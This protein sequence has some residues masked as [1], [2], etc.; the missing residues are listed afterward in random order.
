ME[1]YDLAPLSPL[2]SNVVKAVIKH[3][4]YDVYHLEDKMVINADL[5]PKF[6]E[7][8]MDATLEKKSLE[9]QLL[10]I[11]EREKN[12][13]KELEKMP[14]PGQKL[15]PLIPRPLANAPLQRPIPQRMMPRPIKAPSRAPE[16]FVQPASPPES[17]GAQDRPEPTLEELPALIGY[18]KIDPLL[19]DPSVSIIECEGP[20]KPLSIMRYGQRQRTRVSLYK[21][22]IEQLLE[23]ISEEVHIPLLE[24]V[25]RAAVEG[26]S[27]HAVISPTIGTR[28]VVKKQR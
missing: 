2:V 3:F 10:D 25:F 14:K 16:P 24:G 17:N 18:G 28:F 21:A 20:N 4:R 7:K 5:I 15:N 6:S 8:V 13:M 26:F 9:Q 19:H 1:T 23:K 11:R 12:L 22:E 27:L